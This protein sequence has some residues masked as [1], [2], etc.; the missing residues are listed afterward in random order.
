[1]SQGLLARIAGS[2]SG[3]KLLPPIMAAYAGNVESIVAQITLTMCLL[4]SQKTLIACPL[5]YTA[6]CYDARFQ[7]NSYNCLCYY[8]NNLANNGFATFYTTCL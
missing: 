3:V 2:G 6:V 8:T 4:R 5:S 7:T 1:M